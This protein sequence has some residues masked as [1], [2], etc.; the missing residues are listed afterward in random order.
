MKRAWKIRA[1]EPIALQ[2]CFA[3]R[4]WLNSGRVAE[5]SQCRSCNFFPGSEFKYI[6]ASDRD[7]IQKTCRFGRL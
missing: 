3:P 4:K 6:G 1:G 5:I 2:G 7:K